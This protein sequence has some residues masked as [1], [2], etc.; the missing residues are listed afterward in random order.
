MKIQDVRTATERRTFASAVMV[1]VV[2]AVVSLALEWQ[3]GSDLGEIASSFAS[4]GIILSVAI[5]RFFVRSSDPESREKLWITALWNAA[6]DLVARLLPGAATVPPTAPPAPA[7]RQGASPAAALSGRPA[8]DAG[9]R[10]DA[11]D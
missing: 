5:L 6:V 11:Y 10:R 1:I 4:F 8:E 2:L 7:A 3:S 9:V